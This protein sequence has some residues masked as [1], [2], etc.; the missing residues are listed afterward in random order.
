MIH[1]FYLIS[2]QFYKKINFFF[3]MCGMGDCRAENYMSA[4]DFGRPKELS[5]AYPTTSAHTS[6]Y[7]IWV[8]SYLT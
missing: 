2:F 6:F 8:K 3:F 5:R 1:Y 7:R 4:E